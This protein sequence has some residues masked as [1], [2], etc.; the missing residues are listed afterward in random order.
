M[1]G[2]TPWARNPVLGGVHIIVGRQ[3]VIEPVTVAQFPHEWCIEIASTSNVVEQMFQESFWNRL[4]QDINVLVCKTADFGV[5]LAQQG[6]HGC[7]DRVRM[8]LE[9]FHECSGCFPEFAPGRF[10]AQADQPLDH[11][12]HVIEMGVQV[13]LANHASE[14]ELIHLAQFADMSKYLRILKAL[15]HI[16]GSRC[17]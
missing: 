3:C 6:L 12:L 10:L 7:I 9:R 15:G 14:G 13:G 2:V 16:G 1:D 4:L 5:Q 8:L 11:L 17:P